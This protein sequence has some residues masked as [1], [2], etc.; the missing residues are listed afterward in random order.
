MKEIK[1]SAEED[2]AALEEAIS[3]IGS[4]TSGIRGGGDGSAGCYSLQPPLVWHIPQF[5]TDENSVIVLVVH[6]TSSIN[7]DSINLWAKNQNLT[8]YASGEWC[9]VICTNKT[10]VESD[11]SLL[12]GAELVHFM[13]MRMPTVVQTAQFGESPIMFE[14]DIIFSSNWIRVSSGET[15]HG[16]YGVRDMSKKDITLNKY[17]KIGSTYKVELTTKNAVN[18]KTAST[19]PAGISF[20]IEINGIETSAFFSGATTINPNV[21]TTFLSTADTNVITLSSSVYGA[22]SVLSNNY[23]TIIWHVK[24]SIN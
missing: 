7:R 8:T 1:I 20:D 13:G 15:F 16:I 18:I 9:I 24:I 3:K 21:A 23:M 4:S 10:I 19:F 17:F 11:V 6:T 22:G 12:D 5:V 2:R 14:E